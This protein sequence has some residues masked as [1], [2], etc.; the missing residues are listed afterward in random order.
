LLKVNTVPCSITGTILAEASIADAPSGVVDQSV[1]IFPHICDEGH[2]VESPCHYYC[3]T[4][5]DQGWKQ[6]KSA[7]HSIN[8]VGAA[9]A[10]GE[11]SDGTELPIHL[12]GLVQILRI[13][14]L[15]VEKQLVLH[16]A[17]LHLL[18]QEKIQQSF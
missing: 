14:I 3:D 4:T 2:G 13:H 10:V 18:V 17:I 7:N 15:R 1:Y 9:S 6:D 16:V 11:L 8:W 5:N 12:V